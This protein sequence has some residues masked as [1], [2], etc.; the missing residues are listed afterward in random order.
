MT[1]IAEGLQVS[2]VG[3]TLVFVALGLLV[4]LLTVLQRISNWH[5]DS[6][7][8]GGRSVP[9][10]EEIGRS[11]EPAPEELARVAAAAVGLMTARASAGRD[12][13]LGDL[14][15]Q[16]ASSW[17]WNRSDTLDD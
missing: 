6:E 8:R 15:Q 1:P 12:R 11:E 13:S 3:L 10:G 7:Q 4:L 9:A 2:A 16:P 5:L 17:W 14:L